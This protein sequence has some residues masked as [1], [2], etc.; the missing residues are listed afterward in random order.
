LCAQLCFALHVQPKQKD[1]ERVHYVFFELALTEHTRL[2]KFTPWFAA[3]QG[4]GFVSK[5]I[6]ALQ[7]LCTV[8]LC[9]ACLAETKALALLFS[10]VQL[11]FAN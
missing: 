6:S 2:A 7:N 5:Q 8:T 3:N 9:L 4:V 10:L 11:C 1:K